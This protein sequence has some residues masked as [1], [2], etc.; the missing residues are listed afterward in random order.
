MLN[1]IEN[2]KLLGYTAF[3]GVSNSKAAI[4]MLSKAGAVS[5]NTLTPEIMQKTN[6][7]VARRLNDNI[8]LMVFE[9]NTKERNS[10]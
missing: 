1:F 4:H 3:A 6:P 5:Y 10:E 2:A 7:E 9:Q 8:E